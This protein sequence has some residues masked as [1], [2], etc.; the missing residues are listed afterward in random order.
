MTRYLVLDVLI[1]KT[2]FQEKYVE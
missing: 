2:S 1:F